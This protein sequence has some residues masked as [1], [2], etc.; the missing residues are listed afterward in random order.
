MSQQVTTLS[1]ILYSGNF[2]GHVAAKLCVA[3]VWCANIYFC[4]CV[5]VS[6]SFLAA[7][8]SVS[9]N[10]RS[11]ATLGVGHRTPFP[12]CQAKRGLLSAYALS[13]GT[14]ECEHARARVCVCVCVHACVH[15]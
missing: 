6:V 5:N 10:D 11:A 13:F 9:G 8:K 3:G 12:Y 4:A 1:R 14:I 7:S 2:K 15:V